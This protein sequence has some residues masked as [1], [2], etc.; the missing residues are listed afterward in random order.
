MRHAH[1]GE[2]STDFARPLRAKGREQAEEVG[3][4]FV[5]KDLFPDF[6][7]ISPA[8]RTEETYKLISSE[9]PSCPAKHVDKMYNG[10]IHA[11]METLS[12]CPES[13]KRVIL[14]A[15]NPGVSFLAEELSSEPTYIGFSPAD[16]CHMKLDIEKWQDI[17]P[18]CGKIIDNA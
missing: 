5:K 9:W 1:A 3:K 7:L 6:A 4:L 10:T 18:A 13:A 11:L 12:E 2:A 8:A 17:H 16:W 14:V 15:H